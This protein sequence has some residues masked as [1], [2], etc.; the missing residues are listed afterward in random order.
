MRKLTFDEYK[1]IH[2]KLTKNQVA[3]YE[4]HFGYRTKLQEETTLNEIAKIKEDMEIW[5]DNMLKKIRAK[6][7]L[8][9]E[10]K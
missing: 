9:K 8:D 7:I 6:K 5:R 2:K 4:T 1:E 3:Y 10:R